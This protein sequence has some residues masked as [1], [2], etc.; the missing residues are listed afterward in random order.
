MTLLLL[1]ETPAEEKKEGGKGAYGRSL[2]K[3]PDSWGNPTVH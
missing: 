1:R 3:G 2:W